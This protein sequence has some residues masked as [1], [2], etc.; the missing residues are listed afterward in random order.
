MSAPGEPV[1][2]AK[3]IID[4]SSLVIFVLVKQKV[5]QEFK[6]NIDIQA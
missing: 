6:I 4:D 1:G 3:R 2:L 5:L